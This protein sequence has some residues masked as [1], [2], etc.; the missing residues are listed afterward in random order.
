VTDR[1]SPAGLWAEAL[2][3]LANHVAHDFRNTLNGVAVNLEVVRARSARGADS[4]A[5]APFAATAAAQFEVATAG[6]EALLGFAR[7]EPAPADVAAGVAR[8]SRLAGLRGEDRVRVTDESDGR[9]RTTAPVELVR[10]AVARSVLAALADGDTISCEIGVEDGI[11]LRVTGVAPTPPPPDS[12]L[13][14]IALAHGVH[15]AVRG[16]SLELRFP[17]ADQ[18][19]IPNVSS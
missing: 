3:A 9:A 14:A 6:A 13:V 1:G 11:F 16:Q 19:A 8:V 4:A 12:Q 5:I 17:S 7:P 15:I 2:H 18:S 10:A